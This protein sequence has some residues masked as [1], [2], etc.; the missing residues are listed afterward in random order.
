MSVSPQLFQYPVR[1][2]AGLGLTVAL[3]VAGAFQS[4]RLT[5]AYHEARP[6]SFTV[7]RSLTRFAAIKAQLPE[8]AMVGYL[9][10]LEP[11][12]I[13]NS[14]TFRAAQYALAPVLLASPD[15]RLKM[16]WAV[17]NFS[18]PQDFAAVGAAR[19]FELVKDFGQGVVLY[20]AGKAG[21]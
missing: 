1:L 16:E 8:H 9:T 19:G 2:A 21:R 15:P 4:Y 3:A 20:R 13:N 10:D 17:G 14:T 5:A 7:D 12:S 18:R 11:G 6:D